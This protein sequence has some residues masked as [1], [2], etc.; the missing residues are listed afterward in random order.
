MSLVLVTRILLYAQVVLGTLQSPGLYNGVP[1]ILHTH[2][3]LGFVIPIVAFLAFRPRAGAAASVARTIARYGPAFSLLLGLINW[4]G[5]KTLALLPTE[6][7]FIVMGIHMVVGFA[8]VAFVEITAGK[9]RRA[10]VRSQS[11]AT[12]AQ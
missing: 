3:T 5:F 11:P 1:G 2:R 12:I 6:G 7:Y 8:I 9:D 4:I 10:Q